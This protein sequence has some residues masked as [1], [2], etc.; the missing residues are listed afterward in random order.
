MEKS[1]KTYSI[2]G[3]L[4]FYLKIWRKTFPLGL[5]LI[6]LS[7]PVSLIGIYE[8][9]HIPQIILLGLENQETT[10]SVLLR[11]L[12]ASFLLILSQSLFE[13]LETK[14]KTRGSRP[15]MWLYSEPIH[16]KLFAMPYEQL[17]SA[18][19]QNKLS[20]VENIILRGGDGGVIH[21]FGFKISEFLIAVVGTILFVP[22]IFQVDGILLLVIFLSSIINLSYGIFAGKYSEKNMQERSE[23]EKKELYFTKIAEER[24]FSKDLRFYELVPAVLKQFYRYHQ[25]HASYLKREA[26]V[27]FGAV[28]L[29]AVT[30]LI[31]DALAYG[32]LIYRL[33]AGILR[34]SDFVFLAALVMQFSTWMDAIVRSANELFQ[35]SA[36]MQQIR[37]FI[38]V[39]EKEVQRGNLTEKEVSLRPSI[40][41]RNLFYH[42]PNS[43]HFIFENFNLKIRP[44]EKIALV[45]INGAGKTTLIHLL[46]GLLAPTRGSILIDGQESISFAQEEYYKI[47]SP[48]FQDVQIFPESIA[49]NVA[50]DVLWE[51]EK[52]EEAL[53]KAGL[54]DFV[55]GLERKE[56]TPLVR[57]SDDSAID[58][59]G[60]MGQRL[61]LARA[62]YK[63]AKI[64]ILDEPTAALD[65]LAESRIYEEYDV[66]SR[67]KTSIFISH[68]L[69]STRFCDRILFLENGKVLEEGSHEN[70]MKRRGK[71]FEMYEVQSRYY[72][73]EEEAI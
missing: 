24:S 56:E 20:K 49:V 44:G 52:M 61:L 59:S 7:V 19:V 54:K 71:Y 64:N 57:E 50:G 67:G 37:D 51:K 41:F 38:D 30:L 53:C 62:L 72:R 73:Q 55:N 36:Q 48:V 4:W 16:R 5:C 66:M 40:E 31:R 68:R 2:V 9:I 70:L 3:N 8:R 27:Q 13:I 29:N 43:E 46:I 1:E 45:G 33:S 47:F 10:K 21:F 28:I 18:S 15:L 39:K 14:L 26:K 60:G 65:P 6:F 17:I 11:I 35:F 42:Y 12:G 22:N 34:L 23:F 63:D 25:V 69:A 58:L 32:Y